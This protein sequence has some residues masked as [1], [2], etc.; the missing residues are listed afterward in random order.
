MRIQSSQSSDIN[1]GITIS[2]TLA[3]LNAIW[4]VCKSADIIYRIHKLSEAGIC[5]LGMTLPFRNIR[6]GLFLVIATI[7]LWSRKS[8]GLYLSLFSLGW[9]FT[10]YW[11]WR[12]AS[13]RILI[14][15]D[16]PHFPAEIAHAYNLYGAT[17]W[18]VIVLLISGVLLIWELK[19]LLGSEISRYRKEAL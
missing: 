5:T 19:I 8:K 1:I 12:I 18:D 16:I 10:E 14:N 7:A 9:I 15:A 11:L 13:Q 2:A 6:I 17:N 3:C 4:V